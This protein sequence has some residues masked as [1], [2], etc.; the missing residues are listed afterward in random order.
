MLDCPDSSA[1]AF[2]VEVDNLEGAWKLACA[3]A[4]EEILR[5]MAGCVDGRLGEQAGVIKYGETNEVI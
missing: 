4:R 3:C 5:G 2:D 1:I